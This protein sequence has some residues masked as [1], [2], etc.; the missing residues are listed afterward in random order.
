[1]A[2]HTGLPAEA[3]RADRHP[4]PD[5]AGEPGEEEAGGHNDGEDDAATHHGQEHA[6]HTEVRH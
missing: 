5:R 4:H 6:V 2:T 3:Q 1:M